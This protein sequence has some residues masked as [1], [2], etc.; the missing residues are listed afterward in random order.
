MEACLCACAWPTSDSLYHP[1]VFPGFRHLIGG[2]GYNE[3]G[4]PRQTNL[5]IKKQIKETWREPWV[6]AVICPGDILSRETGFCVLMCL[7]DNGVCFCGTHS[8]VSALANLQLGE[9]LEN[10]EGPFSLP[11]LLLR[12]SDPPAFPGSS[13]PSGHWP[14]HG[15]LAVQIACWVCSRSF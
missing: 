9:D 1:G 14:G 6:I 3:E 5:L 8:K 15:Q 10:K 13:A 2:M 12:T 4:F 11:G 7:E